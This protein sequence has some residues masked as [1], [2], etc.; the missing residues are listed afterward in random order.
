MSIIFSAVIAIAESTK[1]REMGVMPVSSTCSLSERVD[2]KL[3]ADTDDEI[4]VR[5]RAAAKIFY[6]SS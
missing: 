6:S 5:S 4:S 1:F 2:V 3:D